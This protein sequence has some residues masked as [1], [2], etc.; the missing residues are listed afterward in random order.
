MDLQRWGLR[1]RAIGL[2]DTPRGC[3]G[4][5]TLITLI[6]RDVKGASKYLKMMSE[7]RIFY[8]GASAS[9]VVNDR[10]VRQ[11]MGQVKTALLK[12]MADN[13]A[14]GGICLFY[15]RGKNNQT[16]S[17]VIIPEAKMHLPK[18]V[19]FCDAKF[20]VGPIFEMLEQSPNAY[21]FIVVDGKG[22]IFALL[23]NGCCKVLHH[24][25]VDLPNKHGRGGQS[26]L[27]FNRLRVEARHNFLTKI[28][29]LAVR[30]FID[31]DGQVNVRGIVIAGVASLKTEVSTRLD[32]RLKSKL[33]QVVDTSYGGNSGLHEAISSCSTLV[34][35]ESF[36]LKSLLSEFFRHL[37]E[38]TNLACFG[39]SN[40]MQA[41]EQGAVNKLLVWENS[42]CRRFVLTNT[43]TSTEQVI[44]GA[45]LPEGVV[46]S[47]STQRVTSDQLLLEWLE[48]NPSAGGGVAEVIVLSADSPESTQFIQGF[49]GLGALLRFPVVFE[50][51]VEE[52]NNAIISDEDDGDGFSEGEFELGDEYSAF[53]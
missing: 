44:W 42:K 37:S 3:D 48:M 4:T 52:L 27:R 47:A 29:E 10:F 36:A 7:N 21:A 49:S 45:K 6:A 16:Y 51:N 41:V 13:P 12:W 18:S 5:Q 25:N 53:F 39:A 38:D 40:V 32:D 23:Q 1:R 14:D 20:H 11:T 31:A 30:A 22:S 50:E 24:I 2:A 9:V 33:M 15:G 8:P 17:E 19:Y 26:A 34:A 43:N 28:N 35:S 46:Q